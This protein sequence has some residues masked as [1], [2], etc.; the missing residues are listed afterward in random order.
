MYNIFCFVEDPGAS[1]FLIGLNSK[2]IN[3]HIYA[4][5]HAKEYLK[6][7]GIKFKTNLNK[8]NYNSFDFFLIGTSEDSNS[9]WPEIVSKITK[10]NIALLV[11]TPTF[12]KERLLFL[13]PSVIDKIDYFFLSDIKSIKELKTLSIDKKKIFTVN[14]QKFVYLSKINKKKKSKRIVFF[15]E[16]SEGI[17]KKKFLKDSEY[18]LKGFSNQKE[19][20]KIVLEEFLLAIKNIKAK[21]HLLLRIHPKED[22]NFYKEYLSFFDSIS[23]TGN[24]IKILSD[25]YLAVGLTSNVLAE[26][27]AMRLNVL[28]ITPK[29]SEFSW[30]NSKYSDRIHHVCNRRNLSKFFKKLPLDQ[31][32]LPIENDK[33]Y[34]LDRMIIKLLNKTL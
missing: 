22:I 5:N 13:K 31:N 24:N 20:T 16:L 34:L 29:K 8:I 23:D 30:I 1:N 33:F 26:A 6:A 25:C 15:S 12:V 14:P 18:N 32:F 7:Y 27:A 28:S 9:S 3:F 10:K 19:R 11:D 17:N 2:K 21:F 4:K